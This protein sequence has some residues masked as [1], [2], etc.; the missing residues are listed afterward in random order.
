LIAAVNKLSDDVTQLKSDNAAL[1][2]QV[3]DLQGLMADH[4]KISR[5]QPQGSSS[6]LP[7]IHKEAVESRKRNSSRSYAEVANFTTLPYTPLQAAESQRI[8]A[9][10]GIIVASGMQKRAHLINKTSSEDA[11]GFITV[12]YKKEAY[13]WDPF[14]QHCQT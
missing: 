7:A 10:E 11:D 4:I 13:L 2:I 3:Q 9:E 12:S 5:Q 8:S 14:S 1:K 6:L